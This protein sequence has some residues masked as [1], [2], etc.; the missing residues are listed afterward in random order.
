MSTEAGKQDLNFKYIKRR[1]QQVFVLRRP[2]KAVFN[3]NFW[4]SVF[5]FIRFRGLRMRS[6]LNNNS[7]AV[8]VRKKKLYKKSPCFEQVIKYG[9]QDR[10]FVTHQTDA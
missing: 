7:S 6:V 5:Y 3:T 9:S 1:L 10:Q 2:P 8:R 4:G